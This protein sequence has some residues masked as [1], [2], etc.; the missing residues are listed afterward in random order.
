MFL[1]P[2]VVFL[3]EV[4]K[5]IK[6]Q[7][8]AIPGVTTDIPE[9][10]SGKEFLQDNSQIIREIAKEFYGEIMKELYKIVKEEIIK[11]MLEKAKAIVAEKAKSY[12]AILTA[13]IHGRASKAL[14]KVKK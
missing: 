8:V 9:V 14:K 12:L 1:S 3:M 4:A 5:A 7:T 10:K 11:L 6:N 13:G 2:D